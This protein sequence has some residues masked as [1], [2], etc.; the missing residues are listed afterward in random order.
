MVGASEK[1]II[2][3]INGFKE[4]HKMWK[5]VRLE[6]DAA[7]AKVDDALK[8]AQTS[9][10]PQPLDIFIA[11]THY[12]VARKKE[13]A[14]FEIVLD[15]ATDVLWSRDFDVLQ[16]S[17]KCIQALHEFILKSYTCLYQLEEY[18][19]QLKE[20]TSTRRQEFFAL[21]EKRNEDRKVRTCC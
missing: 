14:R 2:G 5:K 16:E 6:Y 18:L 11:Q 9:K 20:H 21:K 3:E 19:A 7:K 15:K 8:T 13:A 4:T 1:F 10:K 17:V 12:H